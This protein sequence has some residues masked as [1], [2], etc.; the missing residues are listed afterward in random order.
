MLLMM[1]IFMDVHHLLAH[2]IVKELYQEVQ[3]EKLEYGKLED[4]LK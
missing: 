4:K 2:L 1:L 3:K